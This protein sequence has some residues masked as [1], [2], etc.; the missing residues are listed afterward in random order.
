KENIQLFSSPEYKRY[1]VVSGILLFGTL[2][3]LGPA[4]IVLTIGSNE[5]EIISFFEL[6][7]A[8]GVMF[9]LA[10]VFV[11]LAL[12]QYRKFNSPVT[13]G[14]SVAVFSIFITFA[15]F[16]PLMHVNSLPSAQSIPGY[17]FEEEISK[18]A[19]NPCYRLI[20]NAPGLK[21]YSDCVRLAGFCRLEDLSVRKGLLG[22]NVLKCSNLSREPIRN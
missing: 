10:L 4:G 13:Y 18:R 7:P 2:F 12:R 1:V 8:I 11:H 3:V 9:A 6:L 15:L 17:Q 20:A 22:A 21:N 14:V 19:L 5:T 16:L